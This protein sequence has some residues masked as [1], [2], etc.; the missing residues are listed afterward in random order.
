MKH[1]EHNRTNVFLK[2][3]LTMKRKDLEHFEATLIVRSTEFAYE[4]KPA[5][6]DPALGLEAK[7]VSPPRG[8]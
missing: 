7:P 8:R 5:Q 6:R 4:S 3:E 1:V 2:I